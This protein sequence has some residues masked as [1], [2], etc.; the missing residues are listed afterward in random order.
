MVSDYWGHTGY[1]LMGSFLCQFIRKTCLY[2]FDTVKSH[3]Y[4]V[5]LG[6]TEVCNIF[7]IS[8]QKT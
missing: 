4:I 5:K 6:L 1:T 3:Y 8:A 7:L 2:D